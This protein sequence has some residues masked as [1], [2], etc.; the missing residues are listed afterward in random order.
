MRKTVLVSMVLAAALCGCTGGKHGREPEDTVLAQVF[1]VD[2]MDGV[3]ILT[4]AGPNGKGE[5]V[6]QTAEGRN[7][8]EAFAAMPGSGEEWISVKNV[9]HILLGDG[10]DPEETLS[11]I[12]D[13]GGMSWRSRVWYVPIA[14]AIIKE[15]EDGGG[16]RLTV[17]EQTREKTTS[18]LDVLAGLKEKG[19]T[20]VPALTRMKGQL[21]ISGVLTY[22]VV[23]GS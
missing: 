2:R 10:V 21:E 4:A 20:S 7:L 8:A 18:V 17:L 15:E 5:T 9:T 3:C 16:G 6:I 11:F 22:T 19:E 23:R 1:G 13:D 14:E 12:L